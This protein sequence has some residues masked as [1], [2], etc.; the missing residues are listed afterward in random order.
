M[1]LSFNAVSEYLSR[2]LTMVFKTSD[3][4][5]HNVLMAITLLLIL[6]SAMSLLTNRTYT[7]M[8]SASRFG[9]GVEE[10]AFP[11][12]A[13]GILSRPDFPKNILNI[14]HDGGYIAL[15][16]PGR[17]IFCDTRTAFYGNE[18]YKTLDAALRGQPGAWNEILSKWHPQAIVLNGCWPD[19]G[20]L[21]NRR[22]VEQNQAGEPRWKL[23]Y[24]D[25]STVVL[26]ANLPEYASL[27]KD[28]AIQNQGVAILEKARTAYLEQSKSF[29]KAGNSARLIGAG[30]IY[31]A[32]NRPQEAQSYYEALTQNSPNMAGAWLGLGQ[33]LILQKQISKG[34]A[35]MEK[36]AKITPNNGRVWIGLFQAYQLK[37]DEAKMRH[38]ADQLNKFYK[39]EKA[40]V[41][42]QAVKEQRKPVRK[43]ADTS[44]PPTQ[45]P[46]SIPEMPTELK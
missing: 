11:V 25:G 19:A 4:L 1:I 8:G 17:K 3:S 23:V 29:V 28:A 9:L 26:V 24:F 42:Q 18:F 14:P 37:G 38:A 16:N 35:Y 10:G 32:L 46:G 30:G 39:A 33:S 45:Q 2:T 40:T 36:A 5:L 41:E 12:A 27:I 34:L 21:V 22:I 13:V 31:L 6:V 7:R 15:A 44:A 43:P 20:A